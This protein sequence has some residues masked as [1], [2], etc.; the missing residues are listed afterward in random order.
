MCSLKRIIKKGIATLFVPVCNMSDSIRKLVMPIG[1]RSDQQD[2]EGRRLTFRAPNGK[3]II[4]TN[5]HLN[6]L[7]FTLFW[8]GWE[9]YEPLSTLLFTHLCEQDHDAFIDIGAN[10][11]YFTLVHSTVSAAPAYCFEPSNKLFEILVENCQVNHVNHVAESKAISDSNQPKQWYQSRS[12]MS[13][14][15]EK[16]FRSEIV[17]EYDVECVTLDSY[18]EGLADRNNLLIKIDA[19]SHEEAILRGLAGLVRERNLELIVESLQPF[20]AD[21]MRLFQDN[22][23]RWY[24]I[25]DDGLVPV[26]EL[27]PRRKGELVF[28]N[29]YVTRNRDIAGISDRIRS[30]ASKADLTRT[31]KGNESV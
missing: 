16:G 12:D 22:D 24:S 29:Y 28:Y 15:L 13:G 2:L 10:I 8:R 21:I 4:L 31:T 5:A 3:S 14:S 11:G 27:G 1:M 6:Y 20:A 7:T 17:E 25:C 9:Y 26:R 19:E 23:Y 30:Y 18:F